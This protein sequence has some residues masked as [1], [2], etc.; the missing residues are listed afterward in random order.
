MNIYLTKDRAQGP[1]SKDTQAI[2]SYIE[3]QKTTTLQAVVE[4]FNYK[5]S[6]IYS[7]LLELEALLIIHLSAQEQ[8]QQQKAA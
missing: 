3:A 8:Q 5:R 6:A 7:S 4:S 2:L 1:I